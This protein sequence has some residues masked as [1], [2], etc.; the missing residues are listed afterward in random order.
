MDPARILVTRP[1]PDADR[2]ADHLRALDIEPVIA[3]M[4]EFRLVKTLRFEPARY[5]AI[6]ITS[7]NAIR[8]LSASGQSDA[9]AHL[10]VFAVGDHSAAAASAAGFETV[11]SASGTLADLAHMIADAPPEGEILY[12]AAHHQS[13]DLAGLLAPHGIMTDTQVVYEMVGVEGL[14]HPAAS[15]LAEGAINGAVFYSRRTA[16]QF[17]T[18]THGPQYDHVRSGMECLC[19]SSACAQPL[20]E[21]HFLRISLADYPSNDAMMTL[22]LAFAR[23][24]ISP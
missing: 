18:L 7:A 24:Q 4:L 5:R 17:A 16:E 6:A 11:A 3:P 10:P 22:A 2:T 20:L 13:G 12:L 8:A 9:L 23:E 15:L 1:Q 14:P 21:S 19:L